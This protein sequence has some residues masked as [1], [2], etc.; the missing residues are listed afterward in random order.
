MSETTATG[1]HL[2]GITEEM[3]AL[4]REEVARARTEAIA[5][6][7]AAGLDL[8]LAGGAGAAGMAGLFA[9]TIAAIDALHGGTPPKGT[10]LPLWLS[11]GVVAGLAGGAAFAMLRVALGD[12]RERGAVP[13]EAIKEVGQAAGTVAGEL[14][15]NPS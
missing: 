4:M 15:S 3:A 2:R 11:A 1:E 14:R 6:L 9:G 8:A 7:R 13:R 12:L 10:G 5:N